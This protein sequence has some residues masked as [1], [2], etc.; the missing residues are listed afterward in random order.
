MKHFAWSPLA[1]YTCR[2]LLHQVG[3]IFLVATDV[4]MGGK[5]PN[6][7]SPHVDRSDGFLFCY[8]ANSHAGTPASTC[9]L[10]SAQDVLKF[11][12]LRSGPMGPMMGPMMAPMMG[13]M[14]GMSMHRVLLSAG[15][16]IKDAQIGWR[17]IDSHPVEPRGQGPWRPRLLQQHRL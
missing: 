8:G 10:T 9:G 12:I 14:M 16:M 15:Q 17:A 5:G 6:M 1:C 11:P 2:P 3:M 7:S 4:G 13:P